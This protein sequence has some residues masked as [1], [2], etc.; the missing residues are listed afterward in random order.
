MTRPLLVV[1][2]VLSAALSDSTHLRASRPDGQAASGQDHVAW[3][4]NTLKRMQT[5]TPGMTRGDLL[6]VFTTEGGLSTALR[7]TFVS[8]DCPY[9]KADVE[10]KAVGRPD[11]DAAGRGTPIESNQDII[12]T[13]SRPYLQFSMFD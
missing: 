13:I 7:R 4:A 6:S 5:V 2:L 3:V 11:R 9:F 1:A 8:R 10:F 12:V